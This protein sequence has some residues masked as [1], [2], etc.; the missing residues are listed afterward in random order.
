MAQLLCRAVILYGMVAMVTAVAV[1][2]VTHPKPLAPVIANGVRYSADRDGIDQYVVANDIS[3]GEQTWK[4]RVVHTRIKF[5]V[6]GD[7]QGVLITDLR[8]IGNSL[9]VRDG[10][11]R[12]YSV[13][14]NSH[15]PQGTL[16]HSLR[17]TGRSYAI[18]HVR[19][20]VG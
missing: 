7:V 12:C 20:R 3:T 9:F 6:E 4:V 15:R 18:A 8:L 2:K 10:K 11:A 1:A 16:R 13:D 5:W 19:P 17:T 14:V